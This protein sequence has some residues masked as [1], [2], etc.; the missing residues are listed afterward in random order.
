MPHKRTHDSVCAAYR[1]HHDRDNGAKS[2][3]CGLPVLFVPTIPLLA[4]HVCVE[5]RDTSVPLPIRRN[6]SVRFGRHGCSCQIARLS[7]GTFNLCRE[8]NRLYV[9]AG[10][11]LLSER[12]G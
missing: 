3:R 7:R 1:I 9:A 12:D 6:K 11:V 2:V 4:R 10:L 5:D 8:L